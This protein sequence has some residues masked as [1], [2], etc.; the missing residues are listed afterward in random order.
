VIAMATLAKELG[1]VIPVSIFEKAGPAYF[2]AVVM[3]DA[4]G[5]LMGIYRRSHIP[6]GPG[7][8][9]KYY[10]PAIP[11]SACGETMK[12]EI[13]VGI[14]WDQVVC[15]DGARHGADGRGRAALSDGYWLRSRMT[16]RSTPPR[17]GSRA[18]LGH[19]VSN[20]T[21]GCWRLPNRVGTGERSGVLRHVVHSR[22]HRRNPRRSRSQGG[23]RCGGRP[24]TWM[25]HLIRTP[26][27]R[28]GALP[29]ATG[30]TDLYGPLV[31]SLSEKG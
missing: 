22:S 18:M 15:G 29:S 13:G 2:N 24:S 11:G 28:R 8:Q 14:C 25:L 17:A 4:D 31:G 6:D 3:V 7:Y 23:G 12:G 26:R 20:V 19:A 27:V 9:E 16:H 21:P 10:V 5:S 30:R 1:A